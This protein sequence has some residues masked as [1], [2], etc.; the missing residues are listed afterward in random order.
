LTRA[1]VFLALA[2]PASADTWPS[3][4][5]SNPTRAVDDHFG[6][7]VA[8]VGGD[9]VVGAR[10]DDTK[11]VDAGAAYVFSGATVQSLFSPTPAIADQLGWS[12]ATA[13]ALRAVGSPHVTTNGLGHAGAVYVFGTGGAPRTLTA[14]TPVA[15]DYFGWSLA[16]DG[17]SILVGAPSVDSGTTA[18]AGAAYLFDAATGAL[19]RTFTAPTPFA[20]AQLGY[21][22]AISGTRVVVGAPYDGT[23]TTIPGRAYVF[24]ATSGA[25]VRTLESGRNR[26]GEA[27]GQ[28]VAID[29][30]RV[31]VGAPYDGTVASNAGAVYVF[32]LTS[33]GAPLRLV[34]PRDVT[35]NHR[36]GSAVAILGANIL[37]GAPFDDSAAPAGGAAFVFDLDGTPVA[38]LE[39]ATPAPGDQ[40]GGAV[41]LAPGRAIVAAWLDDDGSG[42]VYVFTDPGRPTTTTSSSTSITTTSTTTTL[43]P[44]TTVTTTSSSSSSE[45][46]TSIQATSSSTI[47]ATVTVTTVPPTATSTTLRAGPTSTTIPAAVA[48]DASNPVVCDDGDPCTVDTCA[49]GGC[50]H[51]AASGLAAVA[52]RLEK[53]E[54]LMRAAAPERFGGLLTAN[55]LGWR[56]ATARRLVGMAQ[57]RPPRRAMRPLRRAE[58]QLTLFASTIVRGERRGRIEPPDGDPP[59]TL[60]RDAAAGAKAIRLKSLSH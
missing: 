59:L 53:L 47:T 38:T 41:A 43:A 45:S 15:G 5:I 25:L 13:G 17:G 33:D 16:G 32:D 21:A 36:F 28:A 35:A 29:G 12:V 24:D 27:F 56:V 37:V 3:T 40:L 55:R 14:P 26:T 20:Y 23:G 9:I 54:V 58:R 51:E 48:C 52:C 10:F 31:L 42:T 60:A 7:S 19:R 18:D 46:T 49:A 57:G 50:T 11:A 1:L 30:T 8:A 2:A 44:S 34:S 39:K 6:R 22:V 4:P